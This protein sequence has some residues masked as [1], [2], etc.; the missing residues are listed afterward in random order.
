MRP[1]LGFG[2][3]RAVLELTPGELDEV[4]AFAELGEGQL[5]RNAVLSLVA[6][7]RTAR[8]SARPPDPPRRPPEDGCSACGWGAQAC[9]APN[10]MHPD[11]PREGS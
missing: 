6:E 2:R 8:L 7:V 1:E 10:C 3:P 11:G 9:F 5:P 4:Q